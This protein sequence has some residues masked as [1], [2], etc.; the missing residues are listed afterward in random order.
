MRKLTFT[1]G[2]YFT[3]MLFD[4]IAPS[5]DHDDEGQLSHIFIVM[6]YI[7]YDINKVMK[8]GNM[9]EFEEDH[10]KLILYNIL[11]SMNFLHSTNVMHRDI[12]PGNIL[13]DRQGGVKICDFG[14]ARTM[15]E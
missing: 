1:E 10:V 9:N 2:N 8:L 5:F 6:E 7:N 3:V 4:L 11:C 12:K 14:L 13:V 15:I